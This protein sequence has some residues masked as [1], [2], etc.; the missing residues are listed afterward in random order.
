MVIIGEI[1]KMSKMAFNYYY[2]FWLLLM[3]GG[4]ECWSETIKLS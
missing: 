1:G 4:D 3:K 2:I